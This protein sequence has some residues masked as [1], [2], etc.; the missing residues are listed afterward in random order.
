MNCFATH[1]PVMV[2]T[3]KQFLQPSSYII[4]KS[5]STGEKFPGLGYI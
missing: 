3:A 4:L 5:T 2:R 1:G